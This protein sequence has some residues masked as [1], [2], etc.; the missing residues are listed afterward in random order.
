MQHRLI[1]AQFHWQFHPAAHAFRHILESGEYGRI[2][3]TEA[4]MTASPGVP[5]GDIRW[6]YDLAG[7]HSLSSSFSLFLHLL[8]L[9][10]CILTQAQADPQWT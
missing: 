6:Q 1:C 3:R 8:C 9:G 2:I 5:K 4:I 10:N 7:L